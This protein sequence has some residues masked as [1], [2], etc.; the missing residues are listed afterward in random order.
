MFAAEKEA[1][2]SWGRLLQNYLDRLWQMQLPNIWALGILILFS[3][4]KWSG[5]GTLSFP[6]V[7]QVCSNGPLR[8]FYFVVEKIMGKGKGII[9]C[10]HKLRPMKLVREGRHMLPK[11]KLTKEIS[12][13][14]LR[15]KLPEFF[16]S[17]YS[18]KIKDIENHTSP[19][20]IST[21]AC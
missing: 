6:R 20:P 16:S 9:N 1:L 8:S 21:Q 2:T 19:H 14:T 18:A 17:L 10:F 12:S 5:S 4:A 15:T 3:N 11:S 7:S 13:W